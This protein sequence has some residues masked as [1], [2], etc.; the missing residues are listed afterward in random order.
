[1]LR[2]QKPATH[3]Q[4]SLLI[5]P[6]DVITWV[7]VFRIMPEF[8]ICDGRQGRF[9]K[10]RKSVEKMGGGQSDAPTKLDRLPI[11]RLESQV[12]KYSNDY[13]ERPIVTM[14]SVPIFQS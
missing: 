1:M 3:N 5:G 9:S 14:L 11:N 8:R 13:F 12:S 10:S 7:K 4:Y 2:V 6:N